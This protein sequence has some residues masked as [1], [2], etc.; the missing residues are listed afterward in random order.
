MKDAKGPRI[1]KIPL[2]ENKIGI[3]VLELNIHYKAIVI[4]TMWH[5][6][7]E[8]QSTYGNEDPEIQTGT[9]DFLQ[10]Y[11]GNSV[12]KDSSFQ[13]VVLKELDI[14]IYHIHKLAHNVS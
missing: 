6:S 10:R 8:R 3:T 9:T 13:Q 12:E 1:A 4:K 14:H 5:Q 11:K 7:K 2:K